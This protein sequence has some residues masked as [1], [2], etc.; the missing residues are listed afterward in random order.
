MVAVET[1]CTKNKKVAVLPLRK[2]TASELQVFL[3]GKMPNANAFKVPKQTADMLKEDLA[4][5]KI[6]MLITPNVMLISM[7]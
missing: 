2:D 7:L 1:G 5:A 6:L 3:T 4:A